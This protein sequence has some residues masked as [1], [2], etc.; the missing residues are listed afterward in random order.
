MI[1]DFKSSEFS[2]SVTLTRID[3]RLSRLDSDSVN[4]SVA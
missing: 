1:D 2:E 4:N 3:D